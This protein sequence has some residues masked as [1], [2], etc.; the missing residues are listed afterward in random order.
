MNAKEVKKVIR[1]AES[2]GWS[3]TVQ[4]GEFEFQKYSPAGQDF[5]I[6]ITAVSAREIYNGLKQRCDDYDC[7]EEA[8]LWL[9][10]SGHGEN[11]A[12]HDMKD[13]YEDM[14]ACKEMMCE[15]YE[16]LWEVV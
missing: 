9:D 15:L 6:A 1:I 4:D 14:E 13:L 16:T 5:N 11:G 10:E 7:S 12:P 8:A 2:L 3:L